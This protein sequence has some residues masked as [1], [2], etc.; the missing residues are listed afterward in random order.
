MN[1]LAR[2]ILKNLPAVPGLWIQLC[3]YAR[4]V[5]RYP[6]SERWA[7]IRKIMERAIRASNVDLVC[8][9]TELLPEQPG[10]LLVGNHQGLF[11]VVAIAATHASP[12][13]AVYKKELE[14]KPFVS[15]I[16]A[17]TRSFAMDRGDVRQSL[18]VIQAVTQQLQNGR[19]Y[20]IFP[21]GTRSKLGNQMNEF[22]GGSFRC[23]V[24]A[25][26]PIVPFAVIDS[27]R[28]LDQKGSAPI[29]VQLHYLEPIPYEA[30]QGMKT[31]EIAEMVRTRIA[32]AIAEHT[33]QE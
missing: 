28:A 17:C 8:T 14:G 22:H 32:Q 12:L 30:Y 24:K 6:E 1:R 33:N 27:F 21:E 2:M 20:L 15:Q 18:T 9:G 29:Q 3:R 16:A 19:T 26:A 4:D 7:H 23:A 10:Y 31:T 13:G 5:E 25:K 11:D